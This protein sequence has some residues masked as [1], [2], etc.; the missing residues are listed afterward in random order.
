MA[1]TGSATVKGCAGVTTAF[2][3]S[4]V[5]AGAG[6]TLRWSSA[7]IP[8]TGEVLIGSEVE[9]RYGSGALLEPGE[10]TVGEAATLETGTL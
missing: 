8:D 4:V 3:V 6:V 7:G 9:L 10:V 2:S 1:G 5:V